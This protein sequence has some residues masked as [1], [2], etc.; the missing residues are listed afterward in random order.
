LLYTW[1]LY[2]KLL[3]YIFYTKNIEFLGFI[4]TLRGIIIDPTHVKAIKEWP[5]PESYRD[6]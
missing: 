1:G 4:I 5:E 3:K 6:I 2:A